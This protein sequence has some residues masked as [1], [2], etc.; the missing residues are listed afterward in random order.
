MW[1]TGT[2]SHLCKTG[3]LGMHTVSAGIMLVIA[4]LCALMR[5]R[6]NDEVA[7]GVAVGPADKGRGL[8]EDDIGCLGPCVLVFLEL[9]CMSHACERLRSSFNTSTVVSVFRRAS[10][11]ESEEARHAG[12]SR[13]PACMSE[14]VQ[15]L[16]ANHM[17]AACM[18][19]RLTHVWFDHFVCALTICCGV[20]GSQLRQEATAGVQDR[21]THG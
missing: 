17:K 6:T 20:E 4:G 16:M 10:G 11:F 14:H 7:G 9:A 2:A 5:A 15:A 13:S 8:Q 1:L 21:R 18:C 12:N 19:P 3:A